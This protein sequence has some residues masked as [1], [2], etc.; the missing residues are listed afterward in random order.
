FQSQMYSPRYI[1]RP[2]AE[3]AENQPVRPEIYSGVIGETAGSRPAPGIAGIAANAAPPPPPSVMARSKAMR[4]EAA[5]DMYSP[6]TIQVSTEGQEI[7]ELFEYRFNT[8]VTIR[9]NE[10]AMVPFLQQKTD[11]RN[12]LIWTSGLNPR[13]AVEIMN[14]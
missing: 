9:K 6:S 11:S 7:G 13:N 1:Q 8:P 10:S 2:F 14:S 12:L 5:A 3:L 4:Q